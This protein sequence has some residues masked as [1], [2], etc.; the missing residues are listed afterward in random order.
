MRRAE[1]EIIQLSGATQ[2]RVEGSSRRR[3]ADARFAGFFILACLD[4]ASLWAGCR[5]AFELAGRNQTVEA[6]FAVLALTYLAVG[7]LAGAFSRRALLS[8][9]FS[10]GSSLKAAVF[11]ILAVWTAASLRGLWDADGLGGVALAAGVVAVLMFAGRVSVA[12]LSNLAAAQFSADLLIVDDVEASAIPTNYTALRA[13]R[14]GV[15][16]ENQVS[17][18]GFSRLTRLALKADRVLVSCS[19]PRRQFWADVFNALSLDAAVIVTDMRREGAFDR[20]FETDLP[21]LRISRGPLTLRQRIHK[22]MFDLAIAV[23]AFIALTPIMGLIWVYLALSRRRRRVVQSR[24]VI[25]L[26]NQPFRT[27]WFDIARSARGTRRFGWRSI[28]RAPM[29]LDVILGQM[30]I[31]GPTPLP[32][33]AKEHEA[34]RLRNLK[35]GLFKPNTPSPDTSYREGW[36]VWRDITSFARLQPWPMD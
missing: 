31:V 13:A 14:L 33:A 28:A 5:V 4:L 12:V 11:S 19:A 16:A 23:P 8:P 6:G 20:E 1:E 27:V 35:P 18:V 32:H 22:R 2:S 30:S 36:T 15:G 10:I 17:A 7:A 24:T 3:G 9:A 25:G 26:R 34:R 29:L 21:I